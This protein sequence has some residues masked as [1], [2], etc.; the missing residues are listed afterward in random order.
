M[1]YIWGGGQRYKF[2]LPEQGKESRFSMLAII[3]RLPR[4]YVET[5]NICRLLILFFVLG[6]FK[7]SLSDFGYTTITKYTRVAEQS[8]QRRY[9]PTLEKKISDT[10]LYV[11]GSDT[12]NC[13]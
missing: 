1:P 5:I 12:G 13:S 10:I 8:I 2:N 11:D 6:E 4:I 3:L 9:I 7:Y